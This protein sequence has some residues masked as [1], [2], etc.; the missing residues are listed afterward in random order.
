MHCLETQ[1]SHICK[2]WIALAVLM[3]FPPLI[4]GALGANIVFSMRKFIENPAIISSIS[5]LDVLFNVLVAS[6]CLY[7]SDHIWTR[8]GRRRPFILAAWAGIALCLFFIPLAN[9]AWNIA[10]VVILWMMLCDVSATVTVL[11]VEIV[12]PHQRMW[13]STWSQWVF[14]LFNLSMWLVVNGRFDD[15]LHSPYFSITG[16][17][18]IYWFSALVMAL[19]FLFMLF[20][21]RELPPREPAPLPQKGQ[22]KTMFKSVFQERQLWPV[23][24]L[25]FSGTLITTGLGAI[26][27][28]LLT[29]QWGYS[30]QDMATNILIGGILNIF[31]LPLIGWGLNHVQRITAFLIGV[32]GMVGLKVAYYILVQFI[33][34]DNRPELF[35]I[36]LMNYPISLMSSIISMVTMPL[37]FDYIPR[38]KMGTAQAGLNIVRNLTRMATL[39][40]VGWWVVW[41]SGFTQPEGVYDYFSGYI[42]MILMELIG[43]VFL[44]YFII[45]VRK[46]KI[47]PVG[48][49]L[50]GAAAEAKS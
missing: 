2:R 20:F 22:L 5:S 33:L 47:K 7:Y 34:P 25:I 36:T 50:D 4:L 32:V 9:S 40:G 15:S 43:C 19:G 44:A 3:G 26:D 17:Q 8:W 42:F 18:A 13:F 46:G 10:L 49:E 23:Y 39:N 35:H 28:L 1:H 41:F 29:E 6:V 27:G 11:V 48:A 30:K 16:E 37:I 31:L 24:L 14:N 21:V 38:D 12:P 45:Q